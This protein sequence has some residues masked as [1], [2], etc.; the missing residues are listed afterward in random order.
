MLLLCRY[1]S[2]DIQPQHR[3][4]ASRIV[5]R[6]GG[7]ALAIDQAAVYIKY[8][9][10][11][12]DRLEDFLTTYEVERQKILSYTSKNFWE[13]EHINVFTIWELSFQQLGSGDDQWK[14]NAAHFLTLSAFFAPT[15]ITESIFRC[16][17]ENDDCEVAWIK[18]FTK[19]DR[20]RDDR[21]EEDD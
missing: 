11:L 20:I 14:E 2:I 4:A 13:Y 1:N 18:I 9:R 8:K 5:E 10:I 21:D 6:L 3:I 12:L 17:Q 7:L 15:S 16:Y 19:N